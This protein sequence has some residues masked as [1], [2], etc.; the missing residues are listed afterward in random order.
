MGQTLQ[1]STSAALRT[2]SA[3]ALFACSLA[4]GA[5]AAAA[6]AGAV[7]WW[8]RDDEAGGERCLSAPSSCASPTTSA[9]SSSAAALRTELLRTLRRPTRTT[10]GG[11]AV[12]VGETWEDEQGIRWQRITLQSEDPGV[13]QA[14]VPLL[15][16]RP[17]LRRC[18]PGVK[19][20]AAIALHGTTK[21]KECPEI[22]SMLKQYAGKRN[23]IGVALDLR[24]H[25][26]RNPNPAGGMK[27]YY[28]ALI[29]SWRAGQA[30]EE[31]E[32]PFVFDSAWDVMRVVDYLLTLDDVDATRIGAT[33][34]SLGGMIT[35]FAGAADQRIR[36]LAPA[37]GVQSF[38]WAVAQN[39][40]QA[41]VAT[42]QPVFDAAAHDLG[43]TSVDS[44]VVAAVW[45]V[46]APGIHSTFDAARSLPTLAPRPL[47]IVN[48]AE[49]PRCWQEGLQEPMRITREAYG[50][51]AAS[52]LRVVFEEGIPHQFTDNMAREI[53]EWF[54]L[55]LDGGERP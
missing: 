15:I 21:H 8:R 28:D 45:D 22:L 33:G 42:L 48:G 13:S 10:A 47:L 43:K 49:D 2:R 50:R 44:E 53:D 19:L 6:G 4:A 34:I 14:S 36:V 27:A 11:P 25:G 20:P 24:Y 52:N 16:A 18:A 26:A 40:W 41:R 55:H 12:S 23:R 46:I 35:W 37:I 17:P 7:A 39:R 3:K 31:R 29:A 51:Q 1:L 32:F 30:S 5:L 38:G 9:A 54:A